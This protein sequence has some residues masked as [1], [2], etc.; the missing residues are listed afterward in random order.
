MGCLGVSKS[1]QGREGGRWGRPAKINTQTLDTQS[2]TK[3][4]EGKEYSYPKLT[5]SEQP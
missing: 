5:V 1:L 4:N 2:D 3:G